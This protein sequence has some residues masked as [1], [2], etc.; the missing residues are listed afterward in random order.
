MSELLILSEE[1]VQR[2]LPMREAIEAMRDAFAA[3]SA[4]EAQIPVRTSVPLE[5]G[6][7]LAMLGAWGGVAGVK[8]ATVHPGNP[9]HGR[10]AVGAMMLLT[11]AATG[12]PMALVSARALT[13]IRTGAGSG[14]ATDL[15]ARPD[16]SVCAVIGAGVQAERQL[17]A[18]CTVRPITRGLV[19]SRSPA[20][21]EDFAVRMT[22]QLEI[23][24]EVASRE[25]LREADV[26]CVATNSLTPVLFNEDVAPGT[27]INAVGAHHPE[28]AEL[29][30][31]L[32]RRARVVVDHRET[33][34]AEAGD[35]LLAGL[36]VLSLPEIGEL[37]VGG[38]QLAS[39]SVSSARAGEVTVFK[40]VGNAVQDLA[41]AVRAIEAAKREGLG[42]AAAL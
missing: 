24:V 23:P 4:G 30:A 13:A 36:D 16:A 3:L 40:S 42:R 17:E 6:L 18:V 29:D 20:R 21:A 26:I 25:R 35:L 14:L 12:E 11:D 5:N 34:A 37:K 38:S 10:P 39:G 41:A 8:W 7:G 33:C 19:I 28:Q 31:A 15:L 9:A 27:H 22:R 1:D 32:V 2:A